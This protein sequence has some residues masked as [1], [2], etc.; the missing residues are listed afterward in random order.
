MSYV[1]V[2]VI[3]THE[4]SCSLSCLNELC[5]LFVLYVLFSLWKLITRRFGAN[6]GQKASPAFKMCLP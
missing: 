6:S 5:K 1:L 2:M 4:M 3:L